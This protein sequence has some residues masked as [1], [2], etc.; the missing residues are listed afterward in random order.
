MSEEKKFV[1]NNF[2]LDYIFS[3]TQRQ[4]ANG[5]IQVEEI[6]VRG[7]EKDTVLE[8]TFDIL[9]KW[10]IIGKKKNIR[11]LSPYESG[12]EPV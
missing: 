2:Y 6:K 11:V 12:H 7:N 5:E 4:K 1:G 9:A 10:Y 3:L 8:A